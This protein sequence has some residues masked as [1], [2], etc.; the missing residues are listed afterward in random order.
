MGLEY[1]EGIETPGDIILLAYGMEESLGGFYKDA[2]GKT[3]N[4]DAEQLFT[5][6]A[7]VEEKHKDQLFKLYRDVVGEEDRSIFESHVAMGVPEGG[8]RAEQFM[9]RI[10]GAKSSLGDV[11]SIAMMFEAQ[12]MD[13]YMRY[14]E[15]MEQE[16]AKAL[17]HDLAEQEKAHLKVLGIIKDKEMV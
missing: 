11:F 15:V 8:L 3:R 7:G 4:S 10:M 2:A 13:L 9:K 5:K 6:L 17:L 16:Q 1:L 12:A 14:A